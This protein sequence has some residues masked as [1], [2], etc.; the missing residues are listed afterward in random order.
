MPRLSTHSHVIKQQFG[1]RKT[2]LRGMV[3]NRCQVNVLA[4]LTNLF[5]VRHQFLCRT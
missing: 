1:F 5:P 2:R 4:A 3:K